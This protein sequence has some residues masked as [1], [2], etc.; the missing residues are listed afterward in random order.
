MRAPAHNVRICP[1]SGSAQRASGWAG[2]QFLRARIADHMVAGGDRSRLKR[3][4][5]SANGTLV[6]GKGTREAQHG[7]DASRPHAIVRVAV[8]NPQLI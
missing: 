4:R 1:K 5:V 8:I 2:Q 7:G 6:R 3:H